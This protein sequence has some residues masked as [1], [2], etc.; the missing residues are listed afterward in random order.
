VF[1]PGPLRIDDL[2]LEVPTLG[3]HLDLRDVPP[4]PTSERDPRI[5]AKRAAWAVWRDGV[6]AYRRAVWRLC[7]ERV[8][9]DTGQP[10][11][12]AELPVDEGDATFFREIEYARCARDPVYFATVWCAVNETRGGFRRKKGWQPAIPY[13]F[14]VALIRWL[15]A[16]FDAT[17]DEGAE[18]AI[19]AVVAKARTLGVTWWICIWVLHGWLFRTAFTAKLVHRKEE[20]VDSP[21]L[22]SLFSRITAQFGFIKRGSLADDINNPLAVPV[23]LRPT[24]FD[25][26]QHKS[27][28]FLVNP[29]NGNEVTGESTT[30]TAG[31]GS[32]GTFGWID[33]AAVIDKMKQVAGSMTETVNLMLLTSSETIEVSAD[34]LDVVSGMQRANDPHLF[35]ISWWLH[36]LY[37]QRWLE[38]KRRQYEEKDNLVAFYREILRDAGAGLLS[39]CYPKTR[40]PGWLSAHAGDFPY[41]TGAPTCF[42]IDPGRDDECALSVLCRDLLVPGGWRLFAAYA[43]RAQEPEFYASLIA[44]VEDARYT[45]GPVERAFMEQMRVALYPEIGYGDPYGGNAV[46]S[47][48]DAWYAKM[49]AWWVALEER[50]AAGDA[51]SDDD[52]SPAAPRFVL[53]ADLARR[54]FAIPISCGWKKEQ[55]SLQGRRTSLMRMLDVLVFD[56]DPQVQET[57]RAVQNQR[58]EVT[59]GARSAEQTTARHDHRWTHR[60]STLEYWAVHL[61]PT[62]DLGEADEDDSFAPYDQLT[63]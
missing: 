10:L 22:D 57:L 37:T 2:L 21:K 46:T 27:G 14:Q 34:F 51:W 18:E 62:I 15:T 19:T 24:A 63:A 5:E 41:L 38:V 6:L 56:D 52:R 12:R 50:I 9:G 30:I 11:P 20:E 8:W 17:E 36:P 47:K 28:R 29:A 4:P 40:E 13:P 45:Y 61:A 55:R 3:I 31:R 44:G 35:E 39:W 48:A 58:W 53:P 1:D 23:W 49:L 59:D 33:E 43:N 54:H 7:G 25:P 26:L 60:T 42:G 32:R 16:C